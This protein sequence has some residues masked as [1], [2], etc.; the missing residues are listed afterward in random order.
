MTSV[1]K[2]KRGP[3]RPPIDNKSILEDRNGICQEPKYSDNA[4][5]FYYTSPEVFKK[6]CTL[7]KQIT[8]RDIYIIF[9]ETEMVFYAESFSKESVIK[10]VFDCDR[11][12]RYYNKERLILRVGRAN[13][14]KIVS[15][16]D[17]TF[18]SSIMISVKKHQG[19]V[20]HLNID[21]FTSKIAMKTGTKISAQMLNHIEFQELWDEK[22][23]RFSFE[24]DKKNFKKIIS[25]IETISNKF[26]IEKISGPE[27]LRFKYNLDEA[28]ISQEEFLNPKTLAI[29]S[30][31]Y[32][33][34]II[35]ATLSVN[36]LKPISNAQIADTVRIYVDS[37]FKLLLSFVID[38]I[39]DCKMLIAIEDYKKR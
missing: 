31:M 38:E 28:L 14:E 25:D 17:P 8:A 30:S 18:H 32:P 35:A 20:D 29:Q 33:N 1:E 4:T 3:G 22:I 11:A 23:Y 26:I 6:L 24:F 34:E 37:Q 27:P 39:A 16:I 13:I 19:I 10:S 7:Y 36:N 5:E 12:H 21:L 9:E 2:K 15:R